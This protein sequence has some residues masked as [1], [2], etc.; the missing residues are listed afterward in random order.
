VPLVFLERGGRSLTLFS[1]A[2]EDHSWIDALATLVTTG[3]VRAVEL[4]RV[5]GQPIA[6]RP[7]IADLALA[8]GF[9]PG[10][11]G[12]ILRR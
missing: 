10:Y 5:D 7:D 1:A 9:R 12:P 11:R 8:N 2:A 4:Q 3:Q 6:E